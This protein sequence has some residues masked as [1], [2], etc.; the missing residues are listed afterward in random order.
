MFKNKIKLNRNFILV[1]I[2]FLFGFGN[3]TYCQYSKLE[4]KALEEYRKGSADKS[5]LLRLI[6]LKISDPGLLV[7]MYNEF[8]LIIN[9]NTK[10]WLTDEILNVVIDAN[11]EKSEYAQIKKWLFDHG[12]LIIA[13]N[14]FYVITAI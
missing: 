1:L 2:F 11:L 9:S 3:I 14:R 8:E 12:I 4:G 7:G 5:D 6:E 13:D 10:F